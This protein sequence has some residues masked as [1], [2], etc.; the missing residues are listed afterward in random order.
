MGRS[1]PVFSGS[2]ERLAVLGDDAEQ[3]SAGRLAQ[4]DLVVRALAD[5][6]LDAVYGRPARARV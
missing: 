3:R 4:G 2:G 5:Q 1:Q 6:H